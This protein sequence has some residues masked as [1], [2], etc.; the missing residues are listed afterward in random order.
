LFGHATSGVLTEPSWAATARLELGFVP[1]LDLRVAGF[2]AALDNQSLRGAEEGSFSVALFAGRVDGCAVATPAAELR[3]L[4]CL[5][6]I[7]GALH[8]RGHGFAPEQSADRL[9]VAVVGG[10]EAQA[11]LARFLAVAAS[12]D[13]L[14]PLAR[15]R[16]Q[17]F[18]AQGALTGERVLTPLGVLIGVGPV[19]RFF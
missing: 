15:H 18:D 2:G 10:I 14:V 5:G 3:A 19:I 17:V 4:A 8:T 13:L 11:Q 7:G 1:W 16:I 9:W 6:G 12:V